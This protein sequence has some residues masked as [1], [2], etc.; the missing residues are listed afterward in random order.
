MPKRSAR[1]LLLAAAV[2]S[3]F[4]GLL[5]AQAPVTYF[6]DALGRLAGVVNGSGESAVYVY[7][8]V[9]NLLAIERHSNGTVGI[10]QFTPSADRL[11][12]QSRYPAPA[13]APH[14]LRTH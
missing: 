12:R 6:Y 7:D 14:P 13:S 2:L 5:H 4:G 9:G 10:V 11:R 8:A 3:L 1:A